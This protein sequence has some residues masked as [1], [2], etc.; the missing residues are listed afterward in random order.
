MLGKNNGIAE[1]QALKI[2]TSPPYRPVRSD[3]SLSSNA[4]RYI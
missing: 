3:A 4:I 2:F 1:K